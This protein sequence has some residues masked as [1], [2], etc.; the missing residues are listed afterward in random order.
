MAAECRR[1]EIAGKTAGLEEDESFDGGGASPRA[2]GS[3]LD[4]LFYGI[5]PSAVGLFGSRRPRRSVLRG[6]LIRYALAV[7]SHMKNHRCSCRPGPFA[8]AARLTS[9]LSLFAASSSLLAQSPD[10]TARLVAPAT[11]SPG[12]R[13]TLAIEMTIGGKWHVNSHTPSEEFLVPTNVVVNAPKAAT[14]P[15]RYPKHVEKKFGFWEKPLRVY[16]G[17]VR[18]ETDLSVPP[19]ASGKIAVTGK[20]SYQAC[21]DQQCFPPAEIAVEANLAVSGM[22]RS[23]R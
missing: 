23:P 15:V 11:V 3:G 4:F 17:T 10:V 7:W 22:T 13:T 19:G 1:S 18:F 14:S 9:L 16:E 5:R 21:N 6:R 20:V 12:S 2:L 8:V